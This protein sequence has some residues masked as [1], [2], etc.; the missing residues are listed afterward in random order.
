MTT[1]SGALNHQVS[2]MLV[3]TEPS[4]EEV[5]VRDTLVLGRLGGGVCLAFFSVS[6]RRLRFSLGQVSAWSKFFMAVS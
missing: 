3:T 1:P 2:Y 5:L 4:V 6:T